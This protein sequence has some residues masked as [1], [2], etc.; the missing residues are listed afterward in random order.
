VGSK[1]KGAWSAEKEKGGEGTFSE[2]DLKGLQRVAPCS[3]G[4][5]ELVGIVWGLWKRRRFKEGAYRV[6]EKAV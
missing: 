2:K 4:N 6:L 5:N 3:S 1:H